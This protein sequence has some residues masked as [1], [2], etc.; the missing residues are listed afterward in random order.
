MMGSLESSSL[1]AAW[2]SPAGLSAACGEGKPAP[3]KLSLISALQCNGAGVW[4][5]PCQQAVDFVLQ[6]VCPIHWSDL[7]QLAPDPV[8]VNVWF[9]EIH[10]VTIFCYGQ[11]LLVWDH[12]PPLLTVIRTQQGHAL[13]A[14]VYQ[15]VFRTV[16]VPQSMKK[17]FRESL[18]IAEF[19]GKS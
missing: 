7:P 17:S 9:W 11:Q 6:G 2:G 4:G 13:T 19:S 14:L 3:Y 10:W 12:S 8:H 5:A 16:G 18:E 1:V 15:G